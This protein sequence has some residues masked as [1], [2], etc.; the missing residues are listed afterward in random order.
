MSENISSIDLETLWT[1]KGDNKNLRIECKKEDITE[2][3]FE[4]I[5]VAAYE[6]ADN[7]ILFIFNEDSLKK[8]EEMDEYPYDNKISQDE[9]NNKQHPCS[10]EDATKAFNYLD[11]PAVDIV[12]EDAEEENGDSKADE[13]YPK[14]STVSEEIKD[15]EEAA[16]TA[17]KEPSAEQIQAETYSTE[18]IDR[19]T[20]E[21][22]TLRTNLDDTTAE[23]NKTKADLANANQAFTDAKGNLD[24]ANTQNNYFKQHATIL[25]RSNEVIGDFSS[26]D[27]AIYAAFMMSSNNKMV[28]DKK[29]YKKF[30]RQLNEGSGNI[31]GD[32]FE[33]YYKKLKDCDCNNDDGFLGIKSEAA[34]SDK[35]ILNDG[36]V[37]LQELC[38]TA[39]KAETMGLVNTGEK[40]G[41]YTVSF[42]Y[43]AEYKTINA[44][45]YG[46][47]YYPSY[48][49]SS[50]TTDPS[51]IDNY[52]IIENNDGSKTLKINKDEYTIDKN[53]KATI[54]KED[55]FLSNYHSWYK[56]TE[57][58]VYQAANGSEQYVEHNGVLYHATKNTDGTYEIGIPVFDPNASYG[59]YNIYEAFGQADNSKLDWMDT[60][61]KMEYLGYKTK[62]N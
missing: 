30:A 6:A 40:S 7:K 38:I 24:K 12:A 29:Q 60:T 61:D 15:N 26:P 17:D 57:D 19:L 9:W 56:I 37:T 13:T 43:Q 5:G 21:N 32:N 2:N 22:A 54:E 42:N 46:C 53:N 55:S 39:E 10:W 8:L 34:K 48:N 23:L 59:F 35:N 62:Q 51:Y 27:E 45:S 31:D 3:I 50:N 11:A 47:N 25:E 49:Y 18:E 58:K 1:K 4:N 36:K 28:L 52:T 20:E 33:E 14:D 16:S 41:T 44:N